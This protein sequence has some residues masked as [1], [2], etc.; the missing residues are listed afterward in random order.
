VS[1]SEQLEPS[2]VVVVGGGYGGV[3]VARSELV[4]YR[5]MGPAIAVPI[6][7]HGG[8]VSSRDRTRSSG[9]RLFPRPKART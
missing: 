9:A 8:R 2:R 3:A 6:G 7:P 5:S 1:T 4:D